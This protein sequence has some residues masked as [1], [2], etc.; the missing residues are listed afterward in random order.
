MLTCLIPSYFSLRIL[1][2][3]VLSRKTL[4]VVFSMKRKAPEA[5]AGEKKVSFL[6]VEPAGWGA[7]L[8]PL[9][10]LVEKKNPLLKTNR[11]FRHSVPGAAR[12]RLWGATRRNSSR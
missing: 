3:A 1:S 7:G 6:G 4:I 5:G 12:L 10:P 2:N 8:V 11:L 9:V